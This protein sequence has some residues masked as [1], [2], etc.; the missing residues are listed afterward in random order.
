MKGGRARFRRPSLPLI[1]LTVRTGLDQ[2]EAGG[3]FT[4][5]NSC[6]FNDLILEL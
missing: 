6:Q 4:C 5:V 3:L 2:I 1:D